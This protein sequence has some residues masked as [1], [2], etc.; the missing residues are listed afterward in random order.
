MARLQLEDGVGS[1]RSATALDEL[2]GHGIQAID[3]SLPDNL[4]KDQIALVKVELPLLLGQDP[5]GVR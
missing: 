1:G 5:R 2:F 3:P 4:F